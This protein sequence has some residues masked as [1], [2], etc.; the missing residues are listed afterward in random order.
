MFNGLALAIVELKRGGYRVQLS[1][2]ADSLAAAQVALEAGPPAMRESRRRCPVEPW[3]A[4]SCDTNDTR[5][6]SVP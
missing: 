6:L 3:S 2:E 4:Q 5:M 1:A